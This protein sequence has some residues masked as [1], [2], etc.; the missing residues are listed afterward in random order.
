[1]AARTQSGNLK[2]LR[3]LHPLFGDMLIEAIEQ[4]HARGYLDKRGEQ[5]K[6]HANRE[7]ALLSHLINKA[8]EWGCTDAPNPCQGVKGFK[9]TPRVHHRDGGVLASGR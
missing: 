9:E 4:H 2:E 3:N 8:W 1:M 5:A 7:K 6:T